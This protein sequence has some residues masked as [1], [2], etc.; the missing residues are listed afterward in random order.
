MV[1]QV[2]SITPP[3]GTEGNPLMNGEDH[4]PLLNTVMAQMYK[5]DNMAANNHSADQQEM[6]DHG[7][8]EVAGP[9][10]S[11]NNVGNSMQNGHSRGDEEEDD[12]LDELNDDELAYEEDVEIGDEEDDDEIAANGDML[13]VPKEEEEGDDKAVIKEEVPDDG[14]YGAA[15]LAAD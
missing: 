5:E 13:P 4:V 9:S 8:G 1:S 7:F 6:I 10:S 15:K 12:D 14:E 11:H 3:P 2:R